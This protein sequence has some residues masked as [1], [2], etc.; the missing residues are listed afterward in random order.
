MLLDRHIRLLDLARGGPRAGLGSLSDS[1]C[2]WP[3]PAMPSRPRASLL[4]ALARLRG[5]GEFGR[6]VGEEPKCPTWLLCSLRA[7]W[8]P[9]QGWPNAVCRR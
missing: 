8:T 1:P 3:A 9:D 6:N 5:L 4:D 7:A 2:G